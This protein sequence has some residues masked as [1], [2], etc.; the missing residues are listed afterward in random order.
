MDL[1]YRMMS[2]ETVGAPAARRPFFAFLSQKAASSP[3]TVGSA[4]S[5]T[6]QPQA[7]ATLSR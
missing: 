5:I 6:D 7:S 4:F 1:L 2:R 3:G